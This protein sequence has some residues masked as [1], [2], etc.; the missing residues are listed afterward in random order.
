MPTT[1]LRDL[2]KTMKSK[3]A[4]SV[5]IIGGGIT[6]YAFAWFLTGKT[7]DKVTI[8]EKN[9]QS[10]GLAKAIETEFGFQIDQFYHFLYNNDSEN[11][12]HFFHELGLNPE[13]T[14][15]NVKSAVFA[16]DA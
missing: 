1:L 10:G 11:T 8:I 4:Q 15:S 14:W 2:R 12:L 5:C 7:S 16:E 3:K 9:M 13:V 6:G